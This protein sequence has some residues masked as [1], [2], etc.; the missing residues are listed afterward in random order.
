MQSWDEEQTEPPLK[1]SVTDA[2]SNSPFSLAFLFGHYDV[3]WGIAE[4]A[5]AQYAPDD[6]EKRYELKNDEEEGYS[7]DD[8]G[9]SSDDGDEPRIVS[10]AVDKKFTIENIGQISMQVKSKTKAL[11]MINW[12]VNTFVLTDGQL[13]HESANYANETLLDYLL[14]KCTDES[15]FKRYIDLIIHFGRKNFDKSKSDEGGY[16]FPEDVFQKLVEKGKVGALAEVI[17]KTGAG[18]PLD[19]L[20]K[21]TGVEVKEKPRFYQGLSVYGKKR[22]VFF[23]FFSTLSLLVFLFF[24]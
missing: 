20:V 12:V 7:D 6:E 10:K 9:A 21:R 24:F 19:H 15:V 8:S 4:I 2:V 16:S 5:H 23:F 1:I 13:V 18:I 11:D 14:K 3:A 22:Y 17:R